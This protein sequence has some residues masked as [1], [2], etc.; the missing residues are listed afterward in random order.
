MAKKKNSTL[1]LGIGNDI[2]SEN[3]IGP[4]LCDFLKGKFQHLPIDFK[5]LNPDA[6][7]I[8]E[9]IQNYTTVIFIDTIKA[10]NSHFGEVK[11][12]SP[13]NLA[14]ALHLISL[15]ES[16]FTTALDQKKSLYFKIAPKIYL[17]TVE[18]QE[19]LVFSEYVTEELAQKFDDIKQKVVEM[20]RELIPEIQNHKN[21]KKND[22][23]MQHSMP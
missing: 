11:L 16:N 21:Q 7:D 1:V 4:T 15:H 2:L 22:K 14:E 18:I 6:G 10:T 12:Y 17:I 23:P 8:P 5:K 3:V 19:D 13:E 9:Y 20:L